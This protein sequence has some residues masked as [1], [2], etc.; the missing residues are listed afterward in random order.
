MANLSGYTSVKTSLFVR[1]QVDEY[2]VADSNSYTSQVLR[3]S[4]HDESIVIDG[5]TYTG[6]RQF[7]GVTASTS[8][9]RPSRDSVS[10]T[11]SGIPEDSIGEIVYSKIKGAPVRIYRGWFDVATGDLIGSIEGRFFGSVNNYAI[12]EDYD[13]VERQASS[14]I[15]LECASTVGVLSRKTSGRKT[16]PQSQKKFYPNDVSMDR[17]PSLRGQKFNFGEQ[18]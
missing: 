16:N 7:L 15:E 6:L 13:V 11:I 12:Q 18:S 1:I 2:R 3:F 14:F 8:E 5:E 10:I 4:D 17:V 9:L